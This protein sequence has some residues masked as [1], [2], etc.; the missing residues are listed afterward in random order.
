MKVGSSGSS[1]WDIESNKVIGVNWGGIKNSAD[2]GAIYNA[3]TKL[4]FLRSFL[5]GD[6]Y[7]EK[8]LFAN[9]NSSEDIGSI[10]MQPT[11][12]P[13][14]TSRESRKRGLCGVVGDEGPK[15]KG[16]IGVVFLLFILPLVFFS[17]I[18]PSRLA[19]HN[20]R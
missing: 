2:P 6:D 18:T 4:D 14:R 13:Q 9:K 16:P 12:E 3:A 11:Q 8:S 1:L 19:L 17:I 7:P 15:Q 5:A 20:K 10:A